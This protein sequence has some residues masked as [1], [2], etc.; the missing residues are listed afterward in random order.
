MRASA[1]L[2]SVVLILIAACAT[3][4]PTSPA[5]TATPAPTGAPSPSVAATEPPATPS[6]PATSPSPSAS[7][8]GASLTPAEAALV[9]LL[10]V[11]AAVDCAPRRTGLPKDAIAGI[12]C[13]P[14]D[15]LVAR[16][17]IYRLPSVNE[18]AY[19]YMTR[20]A[21]AGVDV[22]AGDC[23]RDIPGDE[24]WTP[25][26]GEGNYTDPGVF[27][28]ENS[29]LSPN[30]I[31]CFLDQNGIANVRTTCG[32]TY[33]GILGSAKDLS[34]LVDWAWRYPDGVEPGVPTPPG[35]CIGADGTSPLG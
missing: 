15:S 24:A 26:D 17:G 3:T 33:V 31:G 18:A 32:D 10:R 4:P 12:E 7:A 16:V 2:L 25:G 9:G 19:T 5:P 29:V 22:S 13:R 30:R 27:D 1:G 21:D 14:K 35:I 28:W 20:M 34:N 23:R 11:D 8:S 6:A